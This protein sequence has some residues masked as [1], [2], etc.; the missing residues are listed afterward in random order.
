MNPPGIARYIPPGGTAFVLAGGGSHGAVQVGM[1]RALVAGGVK[2]D[3]VVGTSVGAVNGTFFAADPTFEGINRLARIWSGISRSDIYPVLPLGWLHALLGRQSHVL[4]PRGLARV[5]ERSLSV[6]RLEDTVIPCAV[7]AADLRDGSEVVIREG[8][9]VEAVLASASIP[10]LFPP[11][12][13]GDRNLMDGGIAKNTGISTAVLL[14]AARVIVLPT[15][16]TCAA[17]AAPRGAVAM[18]LHVVNGLLARQ[19]A[20]DAERHAGE[21]PVI[22][23]PPLCPMAV[24]SYDFS[25]ATSLMDRAAGATAHWL[26]AG[27]LDGRSIPVTLIPHTH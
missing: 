13:I 5:L 3:F 18:A 16:F 10:V 11:V 27:G 12:R 2:P 1:L 7:I 21:L 24:S 23:V 17:R 6:R 14:G 8:P 20:S 19:L 26:D 9:A 22:V 4:D 15:G 25:E